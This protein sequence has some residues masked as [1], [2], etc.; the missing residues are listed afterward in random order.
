M[1][2]GEMVRKIKGT[3]FEDEGSWLGTRECRWPLEAG[4]DAETD[5]LQSLQNKMK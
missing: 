1:T 5:S 2:R 3:G 4:K